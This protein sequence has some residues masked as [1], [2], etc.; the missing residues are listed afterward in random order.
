MKRILF[1]LFAAVLALQAGTFA[2]GKKLFAQKCSSCHAGYVPADRLKENFFEKNNTLLHL[3]APTVNMLAYAIMRS[4]KHIGDPRDPEMRGDEIAAYLEDT[5][6]HPQRSNTICD[7]NFMKF[8]DV[9]KP[10]TPPLTEAEY[11]TLSFFFMHYKAEHSKHNPRPAKHLTSTYSMTNI[12]EE[13][14]RTHKR[15]I[16]EAMSPTCHFCKI[17][18][19]DVIETEPVQ[20]LLQKGYLFVKLNV[21]K[22]MFPLGLDKVY[23]H[24]TPSFFVLDANGT[25]EGHYPGSWKQRD[26]T[27]ILN[28]HMPKE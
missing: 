4:P 5:L 10:L 12:L 24:V 7:P 18:E 25:L 20:T 17:M 22:Q 13:A 16:L 3:K 28:H 9:K 6:T 1:V 19:R 11:D 15:V 2:A 23:K 27:M 21:D 14:K 8:Y 26:F